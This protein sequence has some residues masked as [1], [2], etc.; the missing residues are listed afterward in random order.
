[1][2]EFDAAGNLKALVDPAERKA[3][4]AY[5]KASQLVGISYSDG[6]TPGVE[7]DYDPDGNVTKVVDGTGESAFGYDQL[8]RLTEAEDGHG[9]FV[10]YDYNL[11]EELTGILY[12]NGKT[13]SRSF[14]EAGRLE[15][16]SD[17]LGG[18]TTFSYDSDSNVEAISFPLA[19]GNVDEYT[20]DQADQMSAAIFRRGSETQAS[21]SY[22]RDPVGQVEEEVKSGLPGPA[23]ASYEYDEN[24]RLIKGGAASFDYDPADNL[25]KAPGTTNAYNAASQLE[26]SAGVAFAYDKLGG[27]V[28]ATPEAG[29]ATSYGYDQAGN[30][31]SVDRPEEGEVP[32]IEES[33]A[34]DGTGLLA[35]KASGPTTQYFT[36]DQSGSLPLMLSGGATSYIYGPNDQPIE[37]ID[38]EEE[39]SYIHHD[40]LGTTRLLTDSI[41]GASATFSYTPYGD[42]EAKTGTTITSL[43]F[44]GGYTDEATG[45]QYLRA[46][47]YDP[48]TA[49]FLTRDPLNAALRTPY[50]YANGNPMRFV[51]PSGMSCIGVGH[52]GPGIALP[53]LDP[54]DCLGE[55]AGETTRAGASAT[56]FAVDKASL[57]IPPIVF[58]AC[59][60][61]ENWCTPAIVGG[62]AAGIGAN[63]IK[64]AKDPCFDF[65][66][67]SIRDLLV[68][69][70]AA[71]PG[72]IFA[73]TAGRA[74][75]E[76]APVT[77]RMIQV[78]LDAPGLAAELVH[79][80]AGH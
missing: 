71:L 23:S 15:S 68:N 1:M 41:G 46:R 28:E 12:P 54:G 45:L 72:G 49:Q 16:V 33:L 27:R 67:A 60:I 4:Y 64:A 8:G 50:G 38:G 47:F 25:T 73:M 74:G 52:F 48:A 43:G 62:T 63:G 20:F 42:L 70:A 5:D 57:V 39:P 44:A 78:L 11:A 19:S 10:S 69:V 79:G 66:S 6:T 56:N 40:Q 36:W 9:D 17:W 22:V 35:S 58:A 2:E 59:L 3:S 7:F 13:I 61:E 53:T 26:T 29:A 65:W 55:G 77:R 51:D 34:Y 24:E 18:T 21:L 75:P 31:I 30:L 14:D 37:Q 32:A 80:G 76:L